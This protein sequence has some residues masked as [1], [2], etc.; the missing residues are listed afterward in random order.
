MAPPGIEVIVGARNDPSWGPVVLL[1]LGGT[2]AEVLGDVSMRL[3]PFDKAEA[4]AMIDELKSAAVF[5]GFRGAPET[6]KE[7]LAAAI[8]AVGRI[9]LETTGIREIDLNPVRVFG[10]GQGILALDALIIV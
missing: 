7:A 9:V 4:L 10:K 3:A 2:A 1:G 8:V 6:D 5:N